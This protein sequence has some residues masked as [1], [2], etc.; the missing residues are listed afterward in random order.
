MPT[1]ITLSLLLNI[2]VL[3]PVTGSILTNA[4]W[5][6][7]AYGPPSPARGILL[8]VYLAILAGSAAL[9]WKPLPQMVAALLLVQIAYKLLTPFTVGTLAN[10]VVLSNLAI[11]AF[12]AVTVTL[13][14]RGTTA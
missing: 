8:A 9:L 10:P 7:A 1:M 3:L 12:H 4:G 5:V 14:V 6:E 11:A 2:A 13:I